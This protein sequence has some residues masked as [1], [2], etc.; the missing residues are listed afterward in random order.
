MRNL[1]KIMCV[2]ACIF[3]TTFI[4]TRLTGVI[5]VDKIQEWLAAARNIHAAYIVLIIITLLVLDI[6]FAI[7]TLATVIFSGYFL[8]FGFGAMASSM[9]LILAG[10]VGYTLSYFYGHRFERLVIRDEY[11]RQEAQAVFNQYG[12]MMI[13]LSRAMPMLPEVTACMSGI[14]RMPFSK[15][16]IAWLISSIPYVLI[17]TYAGSISTLDNPTPAIVTAIALMVFLWVGWFIFQRVTRKQ[18]IVTREA[19]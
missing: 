16:I 11:K 15:F 18:N 2:L 7:P 13:V 3:A 12:I 6:L 9:G 4:V 14:T 5:S 17:A 19:N 1:I 8:G 10:V